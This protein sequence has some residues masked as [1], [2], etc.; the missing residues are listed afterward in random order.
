MVVVLKFHLILKHNPQ[1]TAGYY[2]HSFFNLC[3]LH[4][5]LLLPP[6]VF[7]GPVLK[8]FFASAD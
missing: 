2:Q 6:V 4:H 7:P 1:S 8:L 5:E 3:T